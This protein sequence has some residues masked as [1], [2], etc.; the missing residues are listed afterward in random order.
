MTRE[1]H[2]RRAGQFVERTQMMKYL[3]TFPIMLTVAA[4]AESGANYQPVLDGPATPVYQSDLAACQTLAR[5]Q[6]QFDQ[7]T[8]GAT[9]MGAG[10]GAVLG[11]VDDD[12]DALGGAVVGAIAG[13]AAGAV[14]ASER[15]KAIVIECLRGRGH[16]VVG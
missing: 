12:G 9:A 5:D 15:R 3:I 4:C 14:N 10:A 2:G 1:E 8:L 7:E 11:E 16:R 13:G 6:K